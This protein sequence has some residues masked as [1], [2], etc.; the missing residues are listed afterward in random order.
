MGSAPGEETAARA[1][2]FRQRDFGRAAET[3]SGK[4]AGDENFPVGSWL[5]PARLRPHVA[6]FY[7][8]ARA[9]DDIADN[10]GLEPEDKIRR[11]DRFEDAITGRTTEDPALATAHRLRDSLAETGVPARH[12][13]DLVAAFKQD[14]VKLRYHD[15]DDLIGYCV[16]SANP[17][18]RYLLDLHGEDPA[19]YPASDA[20]CSALQVI[21][22]LQGCAD[23]YRDL[24]RV[25]LPQDWMADSGVTVEALAAPASSP[26]LRRV[27]DLC[28]DATAGLLGEADRLPANLRSRHL[29]LESAVIVG[30]A[31]RLVRE[32][33]D[34]DPLAERVVLSKAE[35]LRVALPAALGELLRRLFARR[36]SRTAPTS[37]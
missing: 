5:L 32:L 22:H 6:K 17:V 26:G 12:C 1:P 16:L 3:P 37:R 2:E 36:R 7:A 33:R 11:L 20:L 10:P 21:N 24:D 35:M 29:A 13:V 23:D 18:G 9:I 19:G 4:G 25:Y 8:F 30:L 28:L 34:R 27:L 14:A 31:R 15:W